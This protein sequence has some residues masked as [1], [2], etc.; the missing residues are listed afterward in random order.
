MQIENRVLGQTRHHCSL[1]RSGRRLLHDFADWPRE[2]FV[3]T[4][5]LVWWGTTRE[6]DLSPLDPYKH[7][8]FE[9]RFWRLRLL[10]PAFLQVALQYS[11]SALK[12]AREPG[13]PSSPQVHRGFRHKRPAA[14]L[15]DA[16]LRR[17]IRRMASGRD[18][19]SVC[20]IVEM[21][22]SSSA[23]HPIDSTLR[24]ISALGGI[25]GHPPVAKF[26]I[27]REIA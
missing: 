16:C 26:E 7:W 13:P 19:D 4:Y 18:T 11:A 27:H 3:A 8:R 5:A 12:C 6:P 21:M 23:D 2:R 9:V 17:C 24:L 22:S 1:S 10:W 14:S 20:W 15:R 25:I